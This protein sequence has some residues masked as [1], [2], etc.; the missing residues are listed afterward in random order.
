MAKKQFPM[1]IVFFVL[2]VLG[3]WLLVV[4]WPRL[5]TSAQT[6]PFAMPDI[7]TRLPSFM[8]TQTITPSPVITETLAPTPTETPAGTLTFTPFPTRPKMT[9]T[10][11]VTPVPTVTST[12]TPA[13]VLDLV[14]VQ[15]I[16]R[17]VVV[18]GQL[19]TY[20]LVISNVSDHDATDVIL[21]DALPSH[22]SFAGASDGGRKAEIDMDVII[23]PSFGLTLSHSVTRTVAVTVDNPMPGGISAIINTATV[24][25]ER[26]RGSDLTPY[27]NRYVH[28][29]CVLNPPPGWKRYIVKPEDT[30]FS[31]SSLYD[32]PKETIMLYNCLQGN[33]VIPGTAIYLSDVQVVPDK[34][35]GLELLLPVDQATFMGWNEN[36]VWEWRPASRPLEEDEYYVL[37]INHHGGAGFVW[38]KRTQVKAQE[39]DLQWMSRQG[40]DIAW[41][42][43]I[44]RA[45]TVDPNALHEYPVGNEVNPYSETWVFYWYPDPAVGP[46]DPG[47]GPTR[48]PAPTTRPP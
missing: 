4:V 17:P 25:D 6:E 32:T 38:T 30:L 20:T 23:W 27:N 7:P 42:V 16:E 8:L 34:V 33:E 28:S 48:I 26:E 46:P 1:M 29:T 40:P 35:V 15:R 19:V 9:P 13:P 21:I 2:L 37:I 31:L 43:V 14:V 39:Y 5:S 10:H 44:A 22:T 3:G 11:T 24:F 18:P 45:E 12:P 47:T 41:Q 36:V